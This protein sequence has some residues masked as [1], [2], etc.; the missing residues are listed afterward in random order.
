ME[1]YGEVREPTG[2]PEL[3]TV[4]CGGLVKGRMHLLEGDPGTGKTTLVTQFLLN[5]TPGRSLLITLSECEEELR[6]SAATHGWNLDEIE[7]FQLVPSEALPEEQQTVLF[8]GEV[9]L[10]ETVQR[11]IE[12]IEAINPE[13]L[14]IDSISELRLLASDP[15]RFR[16]QILQ[17]KRFLQDR[18]CTTLITDDL[19]DVGSARQLHSVA[20]GVVK[21]ESWE[22]SFGASRYRMRVTKMRGARYQ[23]GWHD[24]VIARGGI[25]VF[26]SL[27]AEEHEHAFQRCEICS[28]L[29][30][31]DALHGGGL[32]CGTVTMLAGPSGSGKSSLAMRYALSAVEHDHHAAYFAFD[33]SYETFHTRAASLGL[34]VD[35]MVAKKRLSWNRLY[36]TRLSPG[37]FVWQVRRSVEDLGTRV[38]II[39]SLNSYLS[40]MPE[41]ETL[42]LQMHELLAYLNNMGVVTILLLAQRG[43]LN[44]VESPIDLSVLADT[45]VL[46]RFFEAQGQLRKAISVIKKRSGVHELMIREYQLFPNGMRVG[47][48]LSGL[49]GILTGVPTEAE[50][51]EVPLLGAVNGAA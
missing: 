16:R 28:G 22:R 43:F 12:R 21:L 47:E 48:P 11:M 41:E 9:E 46:M 23:S 34:D 14:V 32:H 25:R 45:V 31:L 30:E 35:A 37:E 8:S 29:P 13:R 36:P 3:D 44:N 42:I 49:R 7:L 24:Y 26:P 51:T 33:E 2:I 39:D 17:L 15:L 1:M 10:S 38:V 4:L 50:H 27:I 40:T 20:H 5:G 18:Q 6:A 19:T